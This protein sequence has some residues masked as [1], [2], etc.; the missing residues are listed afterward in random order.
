MTIPVVGEVFKRVG[1][2]DQISGKLLSGNVSGFMAPRNG[3]LH[4]RPPHPQA[5]NPDS[6]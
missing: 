3:T 1:N 4:L 5:I 6:Y 2:Q